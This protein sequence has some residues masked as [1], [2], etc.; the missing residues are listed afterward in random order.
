MV[1]IIVLITTLAMGILNKKRN[2]TTLEGQKTEF[3]LQ[4]NEHMHLELDASGDQVPVPNGYVGSKVTGENEINTGYV[5]YEGE[6]E[7]NDTNKDE[8]QRSRNQYVWIPVPDPSKMYGTDANGKKWGKLYEFTTKSGD[9]INEITGE[10]PLNWEETDGVISIINTNE[11]EYYEEEY[12]REPDYSNV[13]D[14]DSELKTVD[15]T[16]QTTHE[17][18][19]QLEQEFNN[20][21]LGVEKYRG[22][23]VGRYETGNIGKEKAVVRKGNGD[24][25]E[26]TWHTMYKKVKNLKGQNTNIETGMIFGSQYDRVI[27][28]LIESES[29]TKEEI[30]YNSTSWGN[31]RNAT[32]EY[33]MEGVGIPLWKFEDSADRL[34]TGSSEYT[35]LNNIYDLAGNVWEWTIETDGGY[36]RTVRG[37]AYNL[38][39]SGHPASNRLGWQPNSTDAYDVR[40]SSN[41]LHQINLKE[42]IRKI[43]T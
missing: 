24:I 25:K 8:A 36:Y 31:Y 38:G 29:R 33:H 16:N 20:M 41:A 7:V 3:N 19:N 27:T 5:I 4:D 30:I 10:K 1:L 11:E 15:L 37:G 28:W 34:A 21:I 35:R 18:L 14:I 22:F 43:K 42:H 17:F 26:Q 2:T 12:Y 39:G 40:L 13:Y 6:E 23:Y 32:F 9:N